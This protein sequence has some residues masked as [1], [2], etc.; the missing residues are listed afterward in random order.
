MRR[1]RRLASRTQIQFTDIGGAG[2]RLM[3]EFL[4]MCD[5][6]GSLRDA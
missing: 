1:V 6:T 5:Q 2:D 4:Q 3:I